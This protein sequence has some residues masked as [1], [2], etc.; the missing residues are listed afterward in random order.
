VIPL[1]CGA[2]L[3]P[4]EIVAAIGAGGMGEVFRARDTKLNR[5]VAIKVLPAAFADDPER[6]ARFTR[7]AQTLASLNHPNI[8]AI[9]SFERL[10][11]A[12][13]GSRPRSNA[14]IEN[15]AHGSESRGREQDV[16]PAGAQGDQTDQVAFLVMEL[17]EGE[18]LSAHIA[19]GP[20][21]IAE[22]LPIARQIAEAVEAAH[23]QGIVHRDLKP[24]NI[25]VRTDG[26]VKVLDF[27]L[28]KAM[29]PAGAST[30]NPNISHSPTLTH[31]GTS[32]GMIIGTAAYMSP[33]Q[34]KGK[35][36]DKRTDIWAFGVVLYEMLTGRRLFAAED[37]SET[38]AAVL[39]RDVNLTSLPKGTPPRLLVLVRDCLIRDPRQRLRDIGDARLVLDRIVAGGPDEALATAAAPPAQESRW[40]RVLPWAT[41]ATFATLAVGM[42]MRA[43][44]ADRQVARVLLGVG[45]AERLLSGLSW[46]LSAGQGRPSRTAMAFSPDGR[47]LV[48]SAERGG[49]VQLYL[50]GLDQLDAIPIA[51]T[52]GASSPFFSPDGQSLGFYEGGALRKVP[53]GGGPV[54]ELCKTG[55]VYG[56]SWSHKDQ[57]VFAHARGGL[58]QVPAAGGTPAEVTKPQTD[59]REHSHRLPQFLPDG[60]TVLF[61]VTNA[62][63]P[64]WDDTR[65]VAQSLST[66]TRKVLIEGAADARFVSTGHLVYVRK[67]TLMAV[68]FDVRRLEVTG[69]A[70]GVV[71]DVMQAANIQ[72]I[73][74]DSGAGQFAV[75]STGSLVYATGGVFPQDRWSFVWVDRTGRS[76]ALRVPPGMWHAPRISPDRKRIA[77]GSTPGGDSDV[78]TYDVQRGALA[79][80]P[81]E[82][83]QGYPIWTPD[84]SRLA[85]S[86]SVGRDATLVRRDANSMVL[87]DPDGRLPADRLTTTSALGSPGSWSP[88]GRAL[89]FTATSLQG[90]AVARS[91][92][93]ASRDGKTE[94]RQL[95]PEGTEPDFSPD[96]RWLAYVSG[97]PSQ[98]YVQPY[99]ALDRRAQVSIEGGTEPVWR[100]DGREM[101][102]L[103]DV[104]A[105]GALKVRVMAVPVTTTPT[106]SAGTPR[107]LF[108]GPFRSDGGHFR[109]YDVTADGQRFLMNREVERPP[110]RVSQMV[111]VQNWALELK[112]RVPAGKK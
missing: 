108:E 27:G 66:G 75:S 56:A 63:F 84:G 16:A 21:A 105:G 57:I 11:A 98:V 55:L 42:A 47:S 4:Y 76:E 13:D 22:A 36:V 92:W 28:A 65:I 44:Q 31:Q 43:P 93:V 106:F 53:V 80:V 64:S 35:S 82:G 23:E 91:V 61:T 72:P 1:A 46:D 109:N 34:A 96:G 95:L 32:A 19:R 112:A 25:K 85:F 90:E 51:G 110:A 37:V 74:I 70:A 9:Y 24:A 107:V 94:P 79:R 69:P 103:H 59:A 30:S 15:H 100:R 78:W 8:A 83:S 104:S 49:R 3:G 101:Y 10:P 81:L 111:L 12:A 86:S 62:F 18:D 5:D 88:D 77:F 17:V 50:R 38:L 102:F 99:P 97:S 33:E 40:S 29:D 89:A 73:L 39:T 2:R 60:E 14:S 54:V 48:M 71:S 67:G 6:L 52:E 20:I 41:A 26:T 7:E 45:P 87:M 58:W 68:P